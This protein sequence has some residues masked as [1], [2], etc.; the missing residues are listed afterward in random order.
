[1]HII[2]SPDGGRVIPGVCERSIIPV[3]NMALAVLLVANSGKS[4]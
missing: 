1:M 2:E 4:I 3:Y